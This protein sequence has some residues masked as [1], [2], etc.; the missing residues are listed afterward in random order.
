MTNR[1]L[2]FLCAAGLVLLCSTA[3]MSRAYALELFGRCIFGECTSDE[4]KDNA[5]LIDPKRYDVD[6]LIVSDE[7]A[8]G[9]AIKSGSQLWQGRDRAV[10][11]SAG[12]IA[13]AKGDYRRILASLYNEGRYG[14]TISIKINGTEAANLPVGTEFNSGDTISVVVDPGPVYL[15]GTAQVEGAPPEPT[16]RDDVLPEL[17]DVGFNTGAEAKAGAV[18]K[19]SKLVKDKWRQQGFATAKVT[20]RRVTANHPARELNVVLEVE[21]GPPASYGNVDVQGTDR[22]DPAFVARQTGL[23]AGNEFDPDDL[24]KAKKRLDRLG[25]F[26]TQKI[27]EGETV[28]EDGTLPMT[29]IVKERKLRRIGLG[30]TVS[31]LEGVGLESYWLHR[32]LFGKAERLRLDAKVGGLGSTFD[33]Q[34]FDYEVGAAF[35][36]P[37]VFT[38]DTDLN[39]K[40]YARREVNESFT[41]TSAGGNLGLTHYYSDE[42]VFNGGVFV[43]AA[44]FESDLGERDFVT[45]GLDFSAIYDSRDNKLDA[46][47]GFY[48]SAAAKPFYEFNYQNFGAAVEAEARTYFSFDDEDRIVLAGRAMVAS[49]VGPERAETPDNFL[50]FAGGG[51]SVRGYNFN[52]IGVVEANGDITGGKSKLEASA[53]LRFKTGGNFGGAIFIDAGTVSA[54][55]LPSFDQD[56]RLGAGFGVRYFTGLGPIRVDVA[57]PLNRRSTDPRFGIYAGIGQAF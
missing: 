31:S 35:T 46:S 39:F 10:G 49:I 3:P 16:M 44:K 7:D 6:F 48:L 43:E 54:D 33:Y 24:E 15:F 51:G 2:Q 5:E 4:E 55:S 14:G 25:V 38:P 11:G 1:R 20:N 36:K 29:L 42:L 37:G 22:M 27:V 26:S 8:V 47:E 28:S 23:V 45:A 34:K 52:D 40:L 53:E 12:V 41:E 50:Y 13:R 30:A 17:E 18:G 19:A 9:D 56:V 57:L 21:S 32:N